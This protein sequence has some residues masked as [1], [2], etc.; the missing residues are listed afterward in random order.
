MAPFQPFGRSSGPAIPALLGRGAGL[1]LDLLIPQRC[2]SCGE[3]VPSTGGLCA[4]CWDRICFIAPPLCLRC[5]LPF[6]L[7]AGPAA[8]CGPCLMDPPRFHR[9]RAV[10]RYD[11][12]SKGLIL[13]FKHGDRIGRVPLFAG[14]MARAGADLL[15]ETE[16][17]VPVPLHPWRLFQ[18]RY[19]QAALLA[20]GLARLTGVSSC[21]D[22]LQ[23][24]RHTPMQGRFGRHG[25]RSNLHGAIRVA[26]P[27]Q[28]AGRHVL[29]IDDVLTSGA[30]VEECARALLENGAVTV[31]VLTLARVVRA[32]G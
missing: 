26:R 20:N 22:A 23:R 15:A 1:L 14:W 30:T 18:R 24:V 11:A 16:V 2:P 19:N 21:P 6:E 28:V 9:A 31:D 17:I 5:G 12:A 3:I 7:D 10:F 29:V 8:I 32:R 4:T 27:A 13:A 25:R